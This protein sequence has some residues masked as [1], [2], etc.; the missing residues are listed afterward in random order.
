MTVFEPMYL[1]DFNQRLLHVLASTLQLELFRFHCQLVPI[2]F[3][4]LVLR[5]RRSKKSA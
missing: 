1:F 2:G 5:K 4:F 3:F